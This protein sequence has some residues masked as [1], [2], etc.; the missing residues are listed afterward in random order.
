MEVNILFRITEINWEYD[1]NI[2]PVIV[3]KKEWI[4]Y[5]TIPLFQE[6]KKGLMV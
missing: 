4:K 1:T 5:P 3:S 2:S 6:V